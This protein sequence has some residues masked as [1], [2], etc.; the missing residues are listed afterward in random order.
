MKETRKMKDI[1]AYNPEVKKI[2]I[3]KKINFKLHKS[4]K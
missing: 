4:K 1:F 3:K 2:S